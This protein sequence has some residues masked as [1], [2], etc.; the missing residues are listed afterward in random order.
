MK[1]GY[2][3]VDK[4]ENASVKEHLSIAAL[5]IGIAFGIVIGFGVIINAIA[6]LFG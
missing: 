4:P 6:N 2:E 1:P 5:A 3:K